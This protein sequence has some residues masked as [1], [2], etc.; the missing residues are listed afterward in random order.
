MAYPFNV[1]QKHSLFFDR[2]FKFALPCSFAFNPQVLRVECWRPLRRPTLL[3]AATAAKRSSLLPSTLAAATSAASR[4]NGGGGGGSDAKSANSTQLTVDCYAVLLLLLLF[5]LLAFCI[6]S[7]DFGWSSLWFT[8][9][10]GAFGTLYQG[11]ING[12]GGPY[13]NC[14]DLQFNMFNVICTYVYVVKS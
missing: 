6:W 4:R 7:R 2:F 12:L 5:C 13:F 10:C 14:F 11:R 9:A 1:F 3:Y 8:A